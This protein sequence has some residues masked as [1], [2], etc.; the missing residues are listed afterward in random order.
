MRFQVLGP[1][2][3]AGDRRD[4]TPG[5]PKQRAVMAL[6]ILRRNRTV[7]TASLIDELWGQCPPESALPTLQTY[8]YKLRKMLD[9]ERP[10]EGSKLLR[11]NGYSYQLQV[12]GGQFD[13]DEFEEQADAGARALDRGAPE[14]ARRALTEALGLWRGP[15]LANVPVGNLLAAEATRLEERRL[16]VLEMRMEADLQL[17]NH[18]SLISE[19]KALIMTHPLSETFY[20]KLITSLAL[21][22]R[23]HEAL[24]AYRRLQRILREELG[25]EPSAELRALQH[26]ILTSRPVPVRQVATVSTLPTAAARAAAGGP[27]VP[28]IAPADGATP[29]PLAVE[30]GLAGAASGPVTV[31]PAPVP[32]Q[33]PPAVAD[34]TGH[35]QLILDLER[36]LTSPDHRRA[37]GRMVS[38]TGTPGV[39]KT[40]TALHLA[41]RVRARFPDGQFFARL[42]GTD[43]E[44][45]APYDVLLDF[46]RSV[47]AL[48]AG[49]SDIELGAATRLYRGWCAK[50]RVLI[51]LDDA[52]S[53]WQVEPLMPGDARCGVIVTSRFAHGLPGARTAA[54][55][56]LR[57]ND[58]LRLLSGVIGRRRVDAEVDA[59]ADI[60]RLCGN[61]PLAVRGAAARLAASPNVSLRRFA[62]QLSAAPTRLAELSIG[63]IDVRARYTASYER[64]D[65]RERWAL[66][67]L[68][69]LGDRAFDAQDVVS[70]LGCPPLVAEMVLARLVECHLLAM[71]DTRSGRAHRYVFLGLARVY[72]A[73]CL[74]ALVGQEVQTY[75]PPA[76]FEV[77]ARSDHLVG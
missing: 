7:Q 50:R 21:A 2:E 29:T 53:A 48:P 62:Q 26:S 55:Q 24:E 28:A 68:C 41:H 32:A 3:I 4:L 5:A 49:G 17:G 77:P 47:D 18:Q 75:F 1:L 61:L 12:S 22:G 56:P 71:V 70:L 43:A 36:F 57:L 8:I 76:L 15:A 13:L 58:C 60:V 14:E 38:L 39:G 74:A 37:E 11:T 64:L 44:P 23:P 27:A 59:A 9:V 63:D 10:G 66:R 31:A 16:R 52:A 33:L 25:L 42:R 51:V 72:A 6:L 35:E 45:A 40:S 30:S 65:E 19:L 34:F 54:V 20:A 69:L 67:L 73:D 46:L